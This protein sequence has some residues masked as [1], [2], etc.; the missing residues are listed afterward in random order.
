[1][2]SSEILTDVF[3]DMGLMADRAKEVTDDIY[4]NDEDVR[5]D[6]DVKTFTD[7]L[8]SDPNLWLD[9]VVE[10]MG[11]ESNDFCVSLQA[12]VGVMHDEHR[13]DYFV[14][15]QR[16]LGEAIYNVVIKYGKSQDD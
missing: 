5:P 13:P 6:A 3:K 9:H 8:L 1:M 10:A 11:L 4:I 2:K 7:R 12:R 16:Q 15:A 14:E